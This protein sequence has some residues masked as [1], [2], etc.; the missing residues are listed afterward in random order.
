MIERVAFLSMHASPLDQPG[1]GDAG[2]MNVYIDELSRTMA[3]RGVGVDVYVRKADR[4]LPDLVDVDRSYRVHHVEAGPLQPL[5]ISRLARHVRSFADGVMGRFDAEP[6]IV[7]SHY[8]LSGWA[9][10][11]IRRTLGIP[12]ANSFHTL[13][14]V[15]DL[16]KRADD[17]PE[18]LLR[19]ATEHEVIEESDCVVASTPS[20][21]SHLM[22]HYGA[23]P[24]R[25]CTSPPGVDRSVFAPGDRDEAR[26]LLGLDDGPVALF[27]GRIQPLKGIDVALAAADLVPDLT[28]LVVGGPSG[29]QGE[30]ELDRLKERSANRRVHFVD[31]VPHRQLADYYRAADVLL[32]PSRSESFGLV[33][34]EA[35]T[36]G[37]PVVAARVGGLEDVVSDGVSG[38]LVD[39]WDPV[40]Y[41]IAMEKVIGDGGLAAGALEWS[42][43]F[44]WEATANRFLELY[45]GAVQGRETLS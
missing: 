10:L 31:P 34:A 25:I 15:K 3:G 20:E 37:I 27:V 35:Q 1:I 41:A 26:R 18:S 30:A 43:R 44:S 13:G 7:H 16:T 4:A 22:E 32:L 39:G 11:A 14:R 33:A 36:C 29:P 9:G 42:E 12:H 2:G 8:W 5:P 21:A 40:G 38:I 6:D 45:E 24:G 17:P 28:L 23:D 19:I